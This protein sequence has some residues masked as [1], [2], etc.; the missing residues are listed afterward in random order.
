MGGIEQRDLSRWERRGRTATAKCEQQNSEAEIQ[1]MAYCRLS[2]SWHGGT[3]S[4]EC[5]E[6]NQKVP[7]YVRWWQLMGLAVGLA[8]IL[9]AGL[10]AMVGQNHFL[11]A[12]LCYLPRDFLSL[13]LLVLA[14]PGWWWGRSR[15]SLLIAGALVHQVFVLR[16]MRATP[17]VAPNASHELRTAFVNR[18]DQDDA[19]WTKWIT[20]MQP[21]V[22]GFTD[23]RGRHGLAVAQ[24][25][26]GNLPFFMR[27]GEHALASR[28]PFRGSEVVRP[29]L[30]AAG[31]IQL[32]YL[33]AARFEV[34]APGGP[35][36]VY[37]VHIRSPRDALSKYR[38]PQLWKWT[39]LGPPAGVNPN[40]TLAFYWKEQAA[41]LAALLERIRQD[42]LPTVVVG[43]FNLPDAGPRYRQLTRTLQDT[44]RMA[45]RGYGYTFPGDIQHW[46]AFGLPWM[47]IDYI[48]A[49]QDWTVLECE[50]QDEAAD[51]QHRGVFARL[52][53]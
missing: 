52:A 38:R 19:S 8:V 3:V 13:L 48:L 23:V 1:A 2:D 40:N 37:V 39:G 11:I 34:D 18:G 10:V 36:S 5:D 42:S 28:Y 16:Y 50:V 41:T 7:A 6:S 35:V 46:A 15:M 20:R 9:W 12:P 51:S 30:P 47:R 25:N 14:V 31:G 26:V 17:P 22:L 53:R 24:A 44:H 32:G 29:V 4:G 21:D 45:G 27:V 49:T 33:P 43:D